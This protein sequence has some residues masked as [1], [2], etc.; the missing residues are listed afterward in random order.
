MADWSGPSFEQPRGAAD[1][2][3]GDGGI[4]ISF[5][6]T[7]ARATGWSGGDGGISELAGLAAWARERERATGGRTVHQ[8][9]CTSTLS[10]YRVVKIY[11]IVD[12]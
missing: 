3:G 9:V 2:S 5:L 4:S 12:F 10:S 7:T 11:D 8:K 6:G 1:R